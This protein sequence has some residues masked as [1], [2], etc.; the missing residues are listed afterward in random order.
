MLESASGKERGMKKDWLTET[1]IAIDLRD[2]DHPAASI[3][4]DR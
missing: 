1:Q 4:Q 2:A 3:C